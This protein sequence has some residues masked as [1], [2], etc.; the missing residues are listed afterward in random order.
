MSWLDENAIRRHRLN[1]FLHSLLLLGGMLFLLCLLGWMILGVEGVVWAFT[2]GVAILLLSPAIS[3]A[4][5][6]RLYGARRLSRSEAPALYHVVESLAERASL[7]AAPELYYL[8]SRIMNAFAVGKRRESAIV[9][10][11]GLLRALSLRE[12]TGVL[13]HETSHIRHNDM[14]VMGLADVIS[15][16]T[17]SFSLIG[18]ILV[19]IN[20]PLVLLGKVALP[21]LPVLALLF[22]PTLS[23]LLQLA[24]S[25]TREFD[26]DM[27]AAAISGDPEALASALQKMERYQGSIL[28][29][30]FMPGRREPHPSVLRTHPETTER[31][32]RLLDLPRQAAEAGQP[33][34]QPVY[35]EVSARV[36]GGP[37]TPPG[38]RPVQRPPRW[39]ASGIWH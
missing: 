8:P 26:A 30:I 21:W 2:L 31:V 28:E 4:A 25:R 24:L 18:Q 34:P 13:A 19:L 35:A 38:Y 27:D 29:R 39:R 20:L 3:P 16:I 15:R 10:S 1:N 37:A 22:A 33:L 32:R 23:A 14:W 12:I 36:P 5:V 17:S 6:L 9:V 7:P 11:D